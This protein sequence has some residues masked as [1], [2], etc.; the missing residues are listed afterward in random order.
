MKKNNKQNQTRHADK[1]RE[2]LNTKKEALPFCNVLSGTEMMKA[3]CH[4]M[5]EFRQR[6]FSPDITLWTFLSQV[7]SDDQSCQSAVIRLIAYLKQNNEALPSVNTAAYC[8]ARAR[9][10][11]GLLKEL[12]ESSGRDL[13]EQAPADWLWRSRAVKLLDG[14]GLSMP[15]T[16]ENQKAYPQPPAQKA[17]CGFPHIHMVALISYATGAL[18]DV[19]MGRGEGQGEVGLARDHLI[20]Q[21]HPGDVLLADRNFSNY[22]ITAA[23]QKNGV[24]AVFAS[25][26]HRHCDFR[27]GQRLGKKD[28]IAVWK[29]PLSRP[30][31]MDLATYQSAPKE[32]HVREVEVKSEKKG[33]QTKSLVLMT[34]FLNA[35]KVTKDDLSV[36]YEQRWTVEVDLRSIKQTMKL[37]VL[38]GKTP[39]MIRKEVWAHLLAYNLIRK[40][41]A[42]AAFAQKK[43]LRQLSFKLAMSFIEAFR[44][45]G[46]F[47]DTKTQTCLLELIASRTVGNRPGRREP[48]AVK[49]RPKRGALLMKARHLYKEAPN[50]FP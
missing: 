1:I 37:D 9:L 19:A 5:N 6:I 38:R 50:A 40:I 29:K 34:T 26:S 16:K 22:W 31:W 14:T 44:F 11:E 30:S 45:L 47:D 43:K 39:A 10:P 23:L 13:Q 15:D 18:L 46:L 24:D 27:S 32:L 20:P 3:I 21:L 41:M 36:L 49:R 33:H 17:G 4:N 12:T 7:I 28:H 42:Q 25:N 48:R 2:K 35:K 8:K